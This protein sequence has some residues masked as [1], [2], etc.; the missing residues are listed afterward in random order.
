MSASAQILP[1]S[2]YA[3]ADDP[4]VR[5]D[6]LEA[7]TAARG[8]GV[9]AIITGVE[10]PSYRP[11]GAAMAFLAD[12]RRVGSL[13]SGCIEADLNHHAQM[14]LA[15]GG[16]STLRYGK[17][18]PFFDIRLPC[19]GGLDILLVPRPPVPLLSRTLDLRRERQPHALAFDPV[20][21]FSHISKSRPTGSEG[22]LFYA[23]I[24]PETRFL[25]FG[26]GPET[27]VFAAL[28][29]LAHYPCLVL[30]HDEETLEQAAMAAIPS[31]SIGHDMP[32]DIAADR[33]TAAVLFYHDHEREPPILS[34]LLRTDAFY[35]GAQGSRAARDKR[36]ATLRDAGVCDADLAR[37][38]GPIG[39]IPSTR[40]PR[41][42]AISVLAEILSLQ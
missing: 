18:S 36:L 40:E 34:R 21:G 32:S 31:R 2:R 15:G 5:S 1:F 20:Q 7:L 30:S 3:A 12:G 11:V 38:R 14:A 9:L 24:R 17:G 6:P 39:L 26:K 13:S 4:G 41:M 33:W 28:V 35:V 25:I 42:L 29:H 37:L 8:E 22:G 27:L 23:A 16:C 19:G 10:G